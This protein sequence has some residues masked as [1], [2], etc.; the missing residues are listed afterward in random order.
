MIEKIKKAWKKITG[1]IVAQY[2]KFLPK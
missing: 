2:N 1:W